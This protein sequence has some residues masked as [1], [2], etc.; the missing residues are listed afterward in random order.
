[1]FFTK[2]SVKLTTY[3]QLKVAMGEYV[4]FL[5]E[6]K[7]LHVGRKLFYNTGQDVLVVQWTKST[8]NN[9]T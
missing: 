8:Y 5:Y 7:G 2:F 1:M 3:P 9:E 6:L 4:C